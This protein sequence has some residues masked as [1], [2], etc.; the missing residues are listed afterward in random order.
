MLQL[1]AGH[2]EKDATC[3]HLDVPDYLEALSRQQDLKGVTI[4]LPKEYWGAGLDPEVETSLKAAMAKAEELGAKLVEVSLPHTAY[5]VA[6]YYII[7]M[8]EAS[9]NLARFDGVR[10]G[11][12]AENP[13]DLIDMYVKSR[14]DGFGDEV[15]RRIIIGTYV[16]SA[17]YYDAYYRQGGPGAAS[18]TP[19]FPGRPRT[20]RCYLRRSF[21]CG[22]LEAGRIQ[23]RPAQDVPD[24]YFHPAVN[25]A[26]LPGLSLP[27][28]LGGQSRHARWPAIHRQ[29][30]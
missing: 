21:P 29:G 4:G 15:K 22:G 17:G 7:A 6:T 1:M 12:R 9:S 19:G 8:A 3:A 26:G 2:D 14:S 11:H 20:M 10:Y 18:D 5:A 28:G 30:F 25:L 13:D 23:R 27:V 16:L 24:G